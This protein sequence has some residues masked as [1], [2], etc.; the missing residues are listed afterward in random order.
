MSCDI[1][2]FLLP[3][4]MDELLKEGKPVSTAAMHREQGRTL[5]PALKRCTVPGSCHDCQTATIGEDLRQMAARVANKI[6]SE[7]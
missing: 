1:K 2:T 3:K 4:S 5:N 7:L 6:N